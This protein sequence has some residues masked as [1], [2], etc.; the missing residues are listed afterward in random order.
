MALT[1]VRYDNG[2]CMGAPT[3]YSVDFTRYFP[4]LDLTFD[5]MNTNTTQFDV[6]FRQSINCYDCVLGAANPDLTYFRKAGDRL[7]TWHGAADF[8][9]GSQVREALC[10]S[11]VRV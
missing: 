7:I 11:S 4:A 9:L 1:K 8:F 10:G 3:V 2:T 6:F 5:T